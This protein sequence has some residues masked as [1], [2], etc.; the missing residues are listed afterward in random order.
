MQKI[1]LYKFTCLLIGLLLLIMGSCKLES[2]K[3]DNSEPLTGGLIAQLE[4]DTPNRNAALDLDN[5]PVFDTI[6]AEVIT[7]R[8]IVSASDMANV[9]V[10]F[11]VAAGEG[12]IDNV[13]AGTN[14]SLNMQGLN[15]SGSVIYQ[16]AATSISITA[17][18]IADA[19]TIVMSPSDGKEITAFSF[20]AAANSALSTDVTGTISG[21]NITATAL[22]GTDVTTLVAT[23]TTTGESVNVSSTAQASGTTPNDF[24]SPI[25]YT[26]IAYDGTTQDYIVSVSISSPSGSLFGTARF[27][28]NIF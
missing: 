6:P 8:A 19:G 3:S 2:G 10:D 16:G 1:R 18:A 7:I 5:P 27:G 11:P 14:R 12:V 15:T 26:V 21:T 4:W 25:T 13:P 23:F 24:S 17:G 22:S 9:Q 28:Q 20:T